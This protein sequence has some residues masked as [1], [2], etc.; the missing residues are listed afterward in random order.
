MLKCCYG[1]IMPSSLFSFSFFYAALYYD[2]ED[3]VSCI[4]YSRGP[5]SSASEIRI[6]DYLSRIPHSLQLTLPAHIT[7]LQLR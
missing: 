5:R 2:V 3:C 6:V 4:A 7:F 1:E